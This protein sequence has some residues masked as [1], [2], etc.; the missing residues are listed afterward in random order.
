MEVFALIPSLL[1]VQIFRRIRSRQQSGR[2]YQMTNSSDEK[3]KDP[4]SLPWWFVFVAY[5]LCVLL[6]G[7]SI[8]FLIARSIQFGDLKT[9]KWFISVI[10]GFFSSIC[11]TQPIKVKSNSFNSNCP[12]EKNFSFVEDLSLDDFLCLFLSQ[13]GR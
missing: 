10:T 13:T 1:L 2:K 4:W 8:F 5:A 12:T 3:V 11:L 7:I 9:R 6:A